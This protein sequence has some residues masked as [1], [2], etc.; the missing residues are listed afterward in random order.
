MKHILYTLLIATFILT[1]C[2][3]DETIEETIEETQELIQDENLSQKVSIPQNR[4]D[5]WNNK[6]FWTVYKDG[7]S[8]DITFP[9]ANKYP[10]NFNL[11][12]KNT[13]NI[14]GGKGWKNGKNR[15][16]GY[17]IGTLS[18]NYEFVGVYGWTNNPAVEYYVIEKGNGGI[19]NNGY[20]FVRNYK[21]NNNTYGFYKKYI[22]NRP[23]ALQAGDCNFWQYKSVRRN[24]TS[25]GKNQGINMGRH[26]SV[27]KNSRN[28]NGFGK[29]VQYQVFGI[30]AYSGNYKANGSMNATVWEN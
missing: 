1:S 19:P 7:G 10:G 27:W 24:Q 18:G 8:A 20:T 29:Y 23:C 22:Q 28:S 2:T 21:A 12:Y 4:T 17:N 15:R 25:I 14:V 5:G 3:N 13:R 30:E 6:R 16:I 26:S 9:S 11:S